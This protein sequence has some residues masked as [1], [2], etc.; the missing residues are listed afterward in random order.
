M[1]SIRDPVLG[2]ALRPLPP[3]VLPPRGHVVALGDLHGDVTAARA[4]LR[5]A[6]A[7]DERDRWVGG[8]MALVQTGDV[9]DRG[10]TE[11]DILDL[12]ES[13]KD[14]ALRSGGVV[15]ALNGNHEL[16][17][18]AGDFRYVTPTGFEIFDRFAA[19]AHSDGRPLLAASPV[20]RGRRV[21]FA[22]GGPFARRFAGQN[23]VQVVGD[24]VFVHGGLLPSHV[25]F[26]LA[27]INEAVRQWMLG[28]DDLPPIL[29]AED[30]PVWV[31][32][33][34][35]QD[36]SE[37][38]DLLGRV[39]AAVPARR[40]VVGHTVQ[41]QGITSAWDGRVWRIDVGL[42]RFYGGPVQVLEIH[43]DTVQPRAQ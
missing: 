38:C 5:L 26:G 2:E 7:I 29:Q 11:R 23:T 17:N 28:N 20:Q 37:T 14:Q 39:L 8:D 18:V 12:L 35:L 43:G 10:D 13:L 6:G 36:D 4:A 30:S 40:M 41:P 19:F 25:R 16:M 22:P 15:L 31:R 21:A 9:L 1:P 24:T 34:A 33:F 27:A 42:S 32:R 3:T